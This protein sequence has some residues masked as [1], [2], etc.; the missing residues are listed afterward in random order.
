MMYS[1][2]NYEKSQFVIFNDISFYTD[3]YELLS[4]QENYYVNVK[5][6][7]D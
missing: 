2:K 7:E 1:F 4:F 5:N 3:M 6:T